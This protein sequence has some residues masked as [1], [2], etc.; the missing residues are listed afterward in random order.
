MNILTKP[1]DNL[2]LGDIEE[3][4][5]AQLPEGQSIEYKRGVPDKKG[6][7]SWTK[8]RQL[9]DSGRNKLLAEIIGFANS[10]GGTLVI[11]IEETGDK[12][13]KPK[14]IVPL[15]EPHE[16]AD[17]IAKQVRDCIDPPISGV[18]VQGVETD[19]SGN[20]IVV[21]RVQQSRKRPHRS[22]PDLKSY[23]RRADRT[24]GMA[25]SE[26]QDLTLSAYSWQSD[27]EKRFEQR[28]EK[29]HLFIEKRQA[30]SDTQLVAFRIT[31][32]P[33]Q[34]LDLG[35]VYNES[36]ISPRMID[37]KLTCEYGEFAVEFPI[38]ANQERLQLR[39]TCFARDEGWFGH[40]RE[41]FQDGS[42]EYSFWVEVNPERQGGI[43]ADY[44]YLNTISV[45]IAN[46]LAQTERVR[47]KA[48]MPELEFGI[49]VSIRKSLD[50]EVQVLKL[51]RRSVAILDVAGRFE[52]NQIDYPRY[53]VRH[54]GEIDDVFNLI[55]E[56]LCNSFGCQLGPKF[57]LDLRETIGPSSSPN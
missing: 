45:V 10:S 5:E 12:P 41:Q 22:A 24:E 1:I 32:I 18:S 8:K 35:K 53:A 47:R 42:V 34:P 49:D 2:E 54:L 19:T 21:V 52:E 29:F 43:G 28:Q 48:E 51:G 4:I 46:A 20:G 36:R 17:R 40:R 57:S 37:Q 39:S 3:L 56:D 50:T 30:K 13:A 55:F 26:I 27:L 31:L 25:M 7:D 23:I 33:L 14:S 9:S 15:A 38:V 16:L 44:L 6:N 11:G